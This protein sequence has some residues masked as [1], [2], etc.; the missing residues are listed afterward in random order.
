MWTQVLYQSFAEGVTS[1]RANKIVTEKKE[2][3]QASPYTSGTNVLR[4]NQQ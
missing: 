2:P 4:G 3:F 1:K